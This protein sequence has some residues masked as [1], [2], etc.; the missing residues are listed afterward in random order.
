M[1]DDF[2]PPP[3]SWPEKFRDA[4]RG[5]AVGVRGQA[6]FD[7]HLVFAV[8]VIAAAAFLRVART[9]WCVLLLCITVVL[10]AE[11]FNSALEYLAKAIDRRENREI[12]VAL[13]I[14]SA[15]VLIAALGAVVVG[16]IVF[17]AHLGLRFPWW[18]E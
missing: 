18:I 17:L 8:L 10:T 16:T 6:S 9:E 3:R 12:A 7:V 5:I 11:M 4:F 15:A 1:T 13:D 2:R 14:G